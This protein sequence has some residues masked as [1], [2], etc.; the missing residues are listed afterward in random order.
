MSVS[1]EWDHT[2]LIYHH[3]A[4]NWTLML[5]WQWMC[6]D[7]PSYKFFRCIEHCWLFAHLLSSL[8]LLSA[9]P[10]YSIVS[11]ATLDDIDDFFSINPN[12]SSQQAGTYVLGDILYRFDDDNY[13]DNRIL[14]AP[15]CFFATFCSPLLP[16]QIDCTC[17]WLASGLFQL[18]GSI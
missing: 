4:L 11:A 14:A 2:Q 16:Y 7:R 1:I 17:T 13:H 10:R 6:C 8:Q 9:M 18:V 5:S 15:L 12:S 3:T